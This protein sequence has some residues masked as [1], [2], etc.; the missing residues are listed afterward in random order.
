MK[1][2]VST[3]QKQNRLITK[4]K[5]ENISV[6]QEKIMKPQKEKQKKEKEKI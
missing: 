2:R 1:H 6:I 5:E 3:N 4:Q